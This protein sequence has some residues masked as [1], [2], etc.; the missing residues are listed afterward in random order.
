MRLAN[1]VRVGSARPEA[2]YFQAE[3]LANEYLSFY[4]RVDRLFFW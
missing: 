1:P 4:S 3:R 2:Y